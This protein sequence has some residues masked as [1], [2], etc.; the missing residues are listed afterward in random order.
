MSRDTVDIIIEILDVLDYLGKL[1]KDAGSYGRDTLLPMVREANTLIEPS[2]IFREC[3][4]IINKFITV[5]ISELVSEISIDRSDLTIHGS[6]K[7]IETIKRRL[8][9]RELYE[10]LRTSIYSVQDRS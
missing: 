3:L 2:K 4:K 10:E 5:R 1:R 9:L 6:A 8:R 7:Y